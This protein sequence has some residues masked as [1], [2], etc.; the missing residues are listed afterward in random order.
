MPLWINF[1]GSNVCK[2]EW[3]SSTSNTWC[4]WGKT[5]GSTP[6][7]GRVYIHNWFQSAVKPITVWLRV[8]ISSPSHGGGSQP[9]PRSH[10]LHFLLMEIRRN[11]L[12][13]Q[14]LWVITFAGEIQIH[15]SN[16][17]IDWT[18]CGVSAKMQFVSLGV[19]RV[20]LSLPSIFGFTR[21][22][23]FLAGGD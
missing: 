1:V 20:S 23:Y 3:P 13:F 16:E 18:C 10:Q 9:V 6:A 17:Q 12:Q 15:A 21:V 5:L 2:E 14:Y 11:N 19:V 22:G 7:Q 8:V 4:I